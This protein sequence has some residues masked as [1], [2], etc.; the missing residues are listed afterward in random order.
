MRKQPTGSSE[1]SGRVIREQRYLCG[2]YAKIAE[3][4]HFAHADKG[5]LDVE[6][7][8]FGV[9]MVSDFASAFRII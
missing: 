4:M 3:I 8:V 6:E 5:F 2:N 9:F 7:G 1:L